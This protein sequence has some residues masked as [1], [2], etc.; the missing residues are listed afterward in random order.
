MKKK[1]KESQRSALSVALDFL[2]RRQYTAL[3]L[4]KRLAEKGFSSEEIDEALVRLREWKYLDDRAYAL[5]YIKYK[6]KKLSRT[7][8]SIELQR[9]GLSEDLISEILEESYPENIEYMNCLL[10]GRKVLIIEDRK[11]QRKMSTS[12]DKMP[13]KIVLRKKVGDKLLSKGYPLDTVKKVLTE[14]IKREN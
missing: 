5:S 8:I 10:L 13:Q 3:Q 11:W 7:M 12:S 14:I 9:S 4:T 1:S 2:S 6:E